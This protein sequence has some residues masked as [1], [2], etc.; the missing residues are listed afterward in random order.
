MLSLQRVS[1]APHLEPSLSYRQG[2]FEK[3]SQR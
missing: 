1:E 3:Y 2:K